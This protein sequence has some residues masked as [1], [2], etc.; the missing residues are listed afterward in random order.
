VRIGRRGASRARS[1]DPVFRRSTFGAMVPTTR[2]GR[3]AAR[4]YERFRVPAPLSVRRCW[5]GRWAISPPIQMPD[6]VNE[7]LLAQFARAIRFAS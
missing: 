4:G 7:L 3:P 2:S 1:D 5:P 6:K